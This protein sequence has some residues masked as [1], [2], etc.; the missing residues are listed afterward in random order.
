MPTHTSDDDST[1]VNDQGLPLYDDGSRDLVDDSS[2]Q[3][4]QLKRPVNVRV[5]ARQGE[6]TEQMLRRFNFAVQDVVQRV[7]D[8]QFY[9]R[10]S[11]RKKREE[12]MRAQQGFRYPR[13]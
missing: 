13:P 3:D 9:E 7:R 10:P 8:L 12:K 5:A 6:S 1:P 11:Q 4:R 2:K